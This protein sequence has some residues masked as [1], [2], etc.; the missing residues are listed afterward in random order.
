[1]NPKLRGTLIWML[2]TNMLFLGGVL[3]YLRIMMK[4]IQAALWMPVGQAIRTITATSYSWTNLTL[5]ISENGKYNDTITV[6]N[7]AFAVGAMGLLYNIYWI[8]KFFRMK[9]SEALSE[10]K[11]MFNDVSKE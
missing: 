4:G 7:T 8:I 1:M 3:F 11:T 2:I 5:V 9:D 6:S 10:N